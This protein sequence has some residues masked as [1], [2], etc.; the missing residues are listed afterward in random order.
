MVTNDDEDLPLTPE[1]NAILGAMGARQLLPDN[2]LQTVVAAANSFGISVNVTL[3]CKG[4]IVSGVIESGRA[5]FE[6]IAKTM[7]AVPEGGVFAAMWST[8]AER[9]PELPKD[10]H[11]EPELDIDTTTYIHLK[12]VKVLS[13]AVTSEHHNVRWRGRISSVDGWFVGSV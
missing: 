6:A 13:G 3:F 7:E 8:M 9:Y 2:L 10:E 12:D 11:A 5:H 4:V 1:D